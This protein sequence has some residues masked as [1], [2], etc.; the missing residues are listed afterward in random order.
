MLGRASELLPEHRGPL[1][2]ALTVMVAGGPRQEISEDTV[3]QVLECV[4]SRP[5]RST[6]SSH[7]PATNGL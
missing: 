1:T 7:C 3:D 4:G 6:A 5:S 2:P